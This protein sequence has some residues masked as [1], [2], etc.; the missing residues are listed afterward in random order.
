MSLKRSSQAHG[1]PQQENGVNDC[2]SP[3]P[4]LQA[5]KQILVDGVPD[6]CYG[7]GRSTD[8]GE[9]PQDAEQLIGGSQAH[10]QDSQ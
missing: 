5:T 6:Q 7:R 9:P 3:E 2:C 8:H 4:R 1:N 10:S